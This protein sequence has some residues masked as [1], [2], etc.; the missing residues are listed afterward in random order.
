M[1]AQETAVSVGLNGDSKV[2]ESLTSSCAY[3]HLW[4]FL[5]RHRIKLKTRGVTPNSKYL[6]FMSPHT[7]YNGISKF[8]A[9]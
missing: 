6:I 8:L 7:G 9:H 2:T 5:A 4:L 1:L 3:D